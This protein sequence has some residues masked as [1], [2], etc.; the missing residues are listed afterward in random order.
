MWSD[1]PKYEGVLRN[2]WSTV[3]EANPMKKLLVKL[4]LL[5]NSLKSYNRLVFGDVVS[6]YKVVV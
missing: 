4:S 2:V 1:H 6:N 5:R 3:V